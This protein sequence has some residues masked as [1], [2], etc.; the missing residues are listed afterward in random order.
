MNTKKKISDT[1]KGA[2]IGA[3]GAIIVAIIGGIFMLLS[4]THHD[5][6][7]GTAINNTINILNT[8]IINKPSEKDGSQLHLLTQK[9]Q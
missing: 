6:D 5:K 2:L 1:I 7:K 3:G 4:Q 9:K 8:T